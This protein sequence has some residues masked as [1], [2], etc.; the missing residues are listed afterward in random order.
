[1]FLKILFWDSHSV[2]FNTRICGHLAVFVRLV[3]VRIIYIILK[4]HAFCTEYARLVSYCYV[5]YLLL[6]C[7]F[8]II[9]WIVLVICMILSYIMNYS[10]LFC[11]LANL[12]IIIK[13]YNVCMWCSGSREVKGSHSSE[14]I[15]VGLVSWMF[16]L[17]SFCTLE[18]TLE[19]SWLLYS[20]N[21]FKFRLLCRLLMQVLHSQFSLV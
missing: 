16:K 19:N 3:T 20:A 7:W 8:F 18:I 21:L 11:H 15:D 14:D 2:F 12:L 1:M 17:N 4:R 6:L 5:K 10:A 9:V 13:I